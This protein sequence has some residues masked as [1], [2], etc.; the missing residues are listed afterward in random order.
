MSIDVEGAEFPIL[1][2]FDFAAF[3]IDII[4]VENNYGSPAVET[5]MSANGYRKIHTLEINDIY[6]RA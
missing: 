4:E 6:Q 5:L 3:D 2:V 1:S